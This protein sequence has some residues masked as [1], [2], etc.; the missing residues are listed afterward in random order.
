METKCKYGLEGKNGYYYHPG[1]LMY[2]PGLYR[3]ENNM[4][5]ALY[6]VEDPEETGENYVLEWDDFLAQANE[7]KHNKDFDERDEWVFHENIEWEYKT[8][9]DL[10][11][12]ML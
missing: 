8:E 3:I 12:L 2:W 4:I 9:K 11:L 10:F 5:T 1:S 7:I 6:Y